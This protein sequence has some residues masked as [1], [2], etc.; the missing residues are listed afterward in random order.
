M[1][2]EPDQY[3]YQIKDKNAQHKCFNL[4]VLKIFLFNFCK[5]FKKQKYINVFLNIYAK[6]QNLIYSSNIIFFFK[7]NLKLLSKNKD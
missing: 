6:L 2:I 1:L 5:K 7:L 4:F 3:C